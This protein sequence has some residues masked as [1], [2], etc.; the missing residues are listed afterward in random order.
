MS[1]EAQSYNGSRK[2]EANTG[3]RYTA[4]WNEVQ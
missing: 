3:K 4:T 1:K 2:A